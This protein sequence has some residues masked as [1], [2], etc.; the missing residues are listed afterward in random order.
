ML[1]FLSLSI[2]HFFFHFTRQDDC[3]F[4]LRFVC[5][6]LSVKTNIN[7]KNKTSP[8]DKVYPILYHVL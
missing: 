4:F 7:G 1:L 6:F 8:N 5:I 2:S 3:I